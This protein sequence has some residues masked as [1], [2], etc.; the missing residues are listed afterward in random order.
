MVELFTTIVTYVFTLRF[1]NRSG[2]RGTRS[3]NRSIRSNARHYEARFG[4]AASSQRS[5]RPAPVSP[6]ASRYI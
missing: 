1:L 3:V 6:V 4:K 2:S 5:Q